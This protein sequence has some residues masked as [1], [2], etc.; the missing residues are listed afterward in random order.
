MF[1]DPTNLDAK[2][3]AYLEIVHDQV[4]AARTVGGFSMGGLI[5]GF[6]SFGGNGDF[7]GNESS[8]NNGGNG[9]FGGN[10]SSLNGV[11]DG[12]FDSSGSPA[13]NGGDGSEE[14]N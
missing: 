5:G 6:G 10:G 3:R 13:N 8:L 11:N 2:G 9:D 12:R 1:M 14:N 4:L 7:G